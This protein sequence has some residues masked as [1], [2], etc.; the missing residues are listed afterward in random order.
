[1]SKVLENT[2]PG[3]AGKAEPREAGLAMGGTCHRQ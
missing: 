1:M 3:A 2:V